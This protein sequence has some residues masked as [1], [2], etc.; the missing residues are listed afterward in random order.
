[1]M[2]SDKIM[3]PFFVENEGD[4]EFG[5]EYAYEVA[6]Q[7]GIPKEVNMV[8][9]SMGLADIFLENLFTKFM[10]NEIPWNHGL[11]L[12]VHIPEDNIDD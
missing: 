11:H 12:V 5:L 4:M 9:P 1:M 2:T 7:K 10:V 6:K 8:F 3:F